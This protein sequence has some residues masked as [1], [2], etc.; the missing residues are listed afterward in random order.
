MNNVSQRKKTITLLHHYTSI[1]GFQGIAE[2]HSLRMTESNFL[3]DPTDCRLFLKIIKEYMQRTQKDNLIILH[4]ALNNSERKLN[5]NKKQAIKDI[6]QKCNFIEYAEW[7]H[8]NIS[9]YV[10]S[11]TSLHDHMIMWNYYGKNGIEL[12]FPKA[13]LI[14]DFRK[15]LSTNEF[16][17]ETP[18][19]YEESNKKL[20]DIQIPKI[21]ELII[22]NKDSS[23]M[24]KEH[25]KFINENS[26]YTIVDLY[27]IKTAVEF[28]EA[29]V[30]DYIE[31]LI[32]LFKEEK[33]HEACNKEGIFKKVFLNNEKLTDHFYWKHDFPYCLLI[34]SSLLKPDTYA[35]EQEHRIV[36]GRYGLDKNPNEEY[37]LAKISDTEIIRPY[38]SLKF[39]TSLKKI[40]LSPLMRNFPIDENDYKAIIENYLDSKKYTDFDVDFSE[41]IVRF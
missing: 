26:Y 22:M 34:L 32:Y 18:V 15:T 40:T 8:K 39:N 14:N 38:V 36:Y 7:L 4:K 25:Q 35:H 16:L 19:I 33:I 10:T 31:T 11:F 13:S 24:L 23:N 1:Y 41:H 28:V 17:I 37:V 3:N 12:T 27:N 30:L 5:D 21:S 9:L 29:Y 6:Y 20:E 2:S